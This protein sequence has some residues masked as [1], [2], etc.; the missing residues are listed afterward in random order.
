MKIIATIFSIVIF[1][2]AAYVALMTQHDKNFR[3]FVKADDPIKF[4]IGEDSFYGT[5]TKIGRKYIHIKTLRL[6]GKP[7]VRR[8][9]FNNTYPVLWF[10]YK[11]AFD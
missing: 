3:R 4:Y 8:I 1:L 10:R 2:A 6:N 9:V 7:I 5:V 11:K